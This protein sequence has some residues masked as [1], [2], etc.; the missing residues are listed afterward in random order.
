MSL[1]TLCVSDLLLLFLVAKSCP[2]LWDSMDCTMPGFPV[3][4][5]LLEFAQTHAHWVANAIQTS[6]S[7]SPLSPSALNL[8]QYQGFPNESVFH[9]KWPKYWSFN[10]SKSPSSEYS[11]LISF[12]TNWFNLLAVQEILKSFLQ[13]H[14]LKASFICHSLLYGPALTSIHDYWKNHSFY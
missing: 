7:L 3:P 5:H 10:F 2:T 13:H 4:Y 14:S 11:G 9:I 8:S 6:H 1:L 12:R